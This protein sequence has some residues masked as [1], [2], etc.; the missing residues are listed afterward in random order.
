MEFLDVVFPRLS[1]EDARFIVST[2]SPGEM[3]ALEAL[4]ARIK[5]M[6]SNS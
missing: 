5:S 2:S 1:D 4:G 3:F 6:E